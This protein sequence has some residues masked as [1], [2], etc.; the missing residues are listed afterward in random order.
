MESIQGL[1]TINI[2]CWWCHKFVSNHTWINKYSSAH[3]TSYQSLTLVSCC[4]Y[5]L[6]GSKFSCSLGHNAFG[7]YSN[8]LHWMA[9]FNGLYI[10]H[11]YVTNKTLFHKFSFTFWWKIKNKEFACK[12]KSSNVIGFFAIFFGF[13]FQATWFSII[14][15]LNWGNT[16][17]S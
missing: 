6:Q 5:F 2:I 10:A 17:D 8:K 12:G 3:H 1:F 7:K 13:L 14:I 4:Q 16:Y 15:S 9:Y 11:N